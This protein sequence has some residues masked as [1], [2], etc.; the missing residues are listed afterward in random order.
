MDLVTYN[1]NYNYTYCSRIW[2]QIAM[3]QINTRNV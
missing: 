3:S 1:Y 2:S